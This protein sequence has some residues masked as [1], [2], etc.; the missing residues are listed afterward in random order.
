MPALGNYQRETYQFRDK[1]GEVKSVPFPIG[2]VTALTITGILVGLGALETALDDI[3][4]GVRAKNTMSIE[5]VSSNEKA[6]SPYAQ[7]ESQLL[8]SLW[9]ATSEAPFSLRIPTIDA[10]KLTFVDGAADLVDIGAGA[11][12]EVTALIEAIEDIVV[13]PWDASEGVVVKSLRFVGSD[14]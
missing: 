2:T 10:S 11:T 9:G 13:T 14:I 4:L 7:I 5:T 6:S 8:V 12:A 3:T 1:T